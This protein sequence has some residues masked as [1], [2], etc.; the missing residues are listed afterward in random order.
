MEGNAGKGTRKDNTKV[1][2]SEFISS[3]KIIS[4]AHRRKSSCTFYNSL[5]MI[6]ELNQWTTMDMLMRY[7]LCEQKV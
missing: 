4:H 6:Y 5:A 7:E 2:Q 3:A 1:I